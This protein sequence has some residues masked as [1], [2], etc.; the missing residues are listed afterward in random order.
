MYTLSNIS[1]IL[2]ETYLTRIVLSLNAS[3][4][5]QNKVTTFLIRHRQIGNIL[6]NF[7]MTILSKALLVSGSI[8]SWVQAKYATFGF[9]CV[10]FA[11]IV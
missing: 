10:G 6:Q 5:F 9:S 4:G 7:H 1:F 11:G 3:V 2:S 8:G